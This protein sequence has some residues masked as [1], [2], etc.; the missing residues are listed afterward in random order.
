MHPAS[1]T[2]AIWQRSLKKFAA[3]PQCATA[4]ADLLLRAS[5]KP[6]EDGAERG[7]S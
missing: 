7:S 2:D 4:P 1:P 6:H 5:P 3:F